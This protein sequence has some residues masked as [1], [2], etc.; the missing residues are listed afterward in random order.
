MSPK[1][2]GRYYHVNQA[3]IMVVA[4]ALDE[5]PP[6]PTKPTKSGRKATVVEIIP[7]PT[8]AAERTRLCLPSAE[9]DK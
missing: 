8:L 9:E 2:I 3:A 7:R 4:A 1:M 5:K 6:E